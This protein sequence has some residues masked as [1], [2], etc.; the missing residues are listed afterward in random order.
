MED[1]KTVEPKTLGIPP[2]KNGPL[3]VLQFVGLE[4]GEADAVAVASAASRI[5]WPQPISKAGQGLRY[6]N[7]SAA[8]RDFLKALVYNC[9]PGP[10]RSTAIS[11]AR[12]AKM[13]ADAAIEL[14]T[15]VPE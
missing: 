14:E 11:R 7:L 15:I 13:W 8:L 10:E 3:Q 4:R 2:A 9:E 12:E 6:A 1:V 5:A